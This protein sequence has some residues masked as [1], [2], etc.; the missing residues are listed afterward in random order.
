[1]KPSIKI[2]K[3][4]ECVRVVIRCRPLS[5]MEN[6]QG[7][8]NAV[9]M[10]RENGEVNVKKPGDDIPKRFTFDSVYSMDSK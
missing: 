10:D 6:N 4:S 5:D 7:R 2:E 9:Q 3:Q 1:M 8:M